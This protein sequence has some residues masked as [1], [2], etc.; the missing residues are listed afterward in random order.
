MKNLS[1]I[2]SEK[3]EQH[4]MKKKNMHEK[5]RKRQ[6]ENQ[7]KKSMYVCNGVEKRLLEKEEE[8]LKKPKNRK[9]KRRKRTKEKQRQMEGEVEWVSGSGYA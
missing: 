1:S 3:Q 9:M 8:N 6:K 2:C 4:G 5:L 7:M